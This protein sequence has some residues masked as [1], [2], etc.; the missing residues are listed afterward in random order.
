MRKALTIGEILVTMAIIGIIAA[1]VMPG[2]VQ[3][4][5][6]Q[7]YVTK[8]KKAVGM[9]ENAVAQACADNNV[10]YF[11]QT[12]YGIYSADGSTQL[13]FL[14]RYLK[15]TGASDRFRT[16]RLL[17]GTESGIA[18]A[19]DRATVVLASGEMLGMTCPDGQNY[20]VFL[21]DTTSTKKPNVFG[22]DFFE[23]WLDKRTNRMYDAFPAEAGNCPLSENARGCFARILAENWEMR[24]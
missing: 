9:I 21:I 4:Y 13:S 11:F 10:S 15:V 3:R 20:C 19:E 14:Q 24:Y 5:E 2:F 1:L 7:I 22:R 17:N 16:Y 12:P 6:G 23:I 18:G 8:L